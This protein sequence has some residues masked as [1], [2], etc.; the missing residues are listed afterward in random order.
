MD[1]GEFQLKFVI[2]QP[3]D[4]EEVQSLIERI[5]NVPSSEVL[6]MPQ[7]VVRSDLEERAL[8]LVD[9]CKNQGYRFCPR[10]HI[11]LFGHTPGT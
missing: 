3:G 4:I 8:W 1:G 6:L 5:G 11:E 7:G 10:L 9:V 2:D